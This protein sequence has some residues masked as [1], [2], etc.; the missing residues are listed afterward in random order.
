M[1][2]GLE[3]GVAEVVTFE[4]QRLIEP[5]G[6]GIGTTIA[7][8]EPSPMTAF[9]IT[10]EGLASEFSLFTIQADDFDQRRA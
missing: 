9:A 10:T 7:E 1:N 6:Q 5:P 4:E 8:V 2:G 3:I